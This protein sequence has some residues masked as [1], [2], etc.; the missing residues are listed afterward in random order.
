MAE[1]LLV[2]GGVASFAQLISYIAHI[3]GAISRFHEAVKDAPEHIS[4]IQQKLHTL[5][6]G[7]QASQHDL[8]SVN[9]ATILPVDL[10]ALLVDCIRQIHDDI[11][12]LEKASQ[13]GNSAARILFRKRFKWTLV[14]RR[15]IDII[16]GRLQSA[17]ENLERVIQL[18][19]LYGRKQTMRS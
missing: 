1:L 11:R 15:K 12:D 5:Q 9:D 17:E 4:R 3:S 13:I 16:F 18:I 19:N 14:E 6:T 2:V 8:L 10:R 7:L